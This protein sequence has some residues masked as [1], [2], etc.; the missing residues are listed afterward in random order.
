VRE[1]IDFYTCPGGCVGGAGN[2]HYGPKNKVF[3]EQY[4]QK[5]GKNM[6]E[7]ISARS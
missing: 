7:N 1:I 6:A 2:L 4:A 3:V 5:A